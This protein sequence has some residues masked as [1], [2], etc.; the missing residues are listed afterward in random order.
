MPSRSLTNNNNN[1][2]NNNTNSNNT[3]SSYCLSARVWVQWTLV[4]IWWRWISELLR[5]AY[6]IP[7]RL[8]CQPRCLQ[9]IRTQA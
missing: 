7:Q 9:Y 4:C 1:N 5:A 6:R 8:S 3:T 2:N